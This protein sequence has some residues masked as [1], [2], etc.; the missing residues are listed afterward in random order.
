[1][2][3]ARAIE[4]NRSALARI[5]A[6]VFALLGLV[7]GGTVERLPQRLYLAAERLLRPAESALRRLIVI[8]ARG[9]VVKPRPK[10]PMPKGL[11][12]VRKGLK[13]MPFRL[14]DRRT[15]FDFI[16]TENPLF[17]EVKTTDSN[18]F[19]PF[20]SH[21]QPPPAEQDSGSHALHL[22]RRLAA[23]SHALETLPRQAQRLAR[24]TER[25]KTL[26]RPKFTSP[27]RPGPPPGHRHK[28]TAEV[29]FVL[30]EC[31]ALAWDVIREDSS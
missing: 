8:A 13:I 12:I 31:H 2:D 21:Y 29:D 5:V 30:K 17:V 1:M 11:V 27:I 7:A 3:W 15:V 9:L 26:E 24:W 22:C 4:I 19:N 18:P 14:F 16:V 20:R 6:E 28:P 10:R 25:R 23:A